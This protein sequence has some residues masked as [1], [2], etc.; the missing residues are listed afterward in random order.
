VRESDSRNHRIGEESMILALR[1]NP[2][3]VEKEWKEMPGYE[4]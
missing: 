1:K 2:E 4:Y 3:P